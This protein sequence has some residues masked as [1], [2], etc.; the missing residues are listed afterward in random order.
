MKKVLLTA[1]FFT[2]MVFVGTLKAQIIDNFDT[3]KGTF[4]RGTA[5]AGQIAGIFG[6]IPELDATKFVSGTQSLKVLYR[7][8]AAGSAPTDNNW[9]DRFLSDADVATAK[10]LLNA[11]T[12]YIGFW[13]ETSTAPIGAKVS[14][15]LKDV[16][17]VSYYVQSIKKDV[18]NDAGV[19]K[20]YE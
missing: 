9:Y 15:L 1:I 4:N 6:T 10:N 17:T 14:L 20:M 3:D 18:I 13:L 2:L 19:F 12:G 16:G 7:D 8:Y 5:T 11:K